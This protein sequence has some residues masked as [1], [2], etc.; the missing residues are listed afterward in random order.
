ME[1]LVEDSSRNR[2]TGDTSDGVPAF[3]SICASAISFA[4][5]LREWVDT[6]QARPV[7]ELVVSEMPFPWLRL[8]DRGFRLASVAVVL[9]AHALLLWVLLAGMPPRLSEDREPQVFRVSLVGQAPVQQP[10]A[11]PDLVTP[12]VD[13]VPAPDI[14]IA[15]E[16]APAAITQFDSATM[17]QILAPRP[18][19]NHRNPPPTL[20]LSNGGAATDLVLRILVLPDGSV[21]DAQVAQSSGQAELDAEAVAFVKTHWRY[22]PATL[23]GHAIQYW[24]TVI[25]RLGRAS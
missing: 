25:V 14:Q 12:N 19:P 7:P 22:L 24:T 16:S 5:S 1:S 8:D 20:S 4:Q 13:L 17:S 9:T 21:S 18:D 23:S 10:V 2:L 15:E 3:R 6:T 11:S